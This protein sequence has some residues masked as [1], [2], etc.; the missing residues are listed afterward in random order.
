MA[1]SEEHVASLEARLAKIAAQGLVTLPTHKPL[2]GVR[3]V[4]VSK[5]PI[6]R[7]QGERVRDKMRAK[8]GQ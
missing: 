4:K 7:L 5:A 2:K 3:L 6:A 1:I 8:E